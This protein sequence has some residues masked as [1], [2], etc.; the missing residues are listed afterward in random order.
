MLDQSFL[1]GKDHF[2]KKK[3]DYFSSQDRDK[4]QRE[5]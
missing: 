1:V 4:G 5:E 3:K 2:S